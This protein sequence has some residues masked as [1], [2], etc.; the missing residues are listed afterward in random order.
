MEP[1]NSKIITHHAPLPWHATALQEMPSTPHQ[2]RYISCAAVQ[3][4]LYECFPFYKPISRPFLRRAP[5]KH[6]H[7]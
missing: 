2:E 3:S 7:E 6:N 4:S 5:E 1:L